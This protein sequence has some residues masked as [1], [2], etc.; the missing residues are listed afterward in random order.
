MKLFA[1]S[2]SLGISFVM[3]VASTLISAEPQKVPDRVNRWIDPVPA[4]GHW[5]F[6]KDAPDP[7]L[8]NCKIISE[9]HENDRRHF[10][11][12]EST[13]GGAS[14]VF[15][16]KHHYSATGSVFPAVRSPVMPEWQCQV[17]SD[18]SWV[19][20]PI[21]H[22][23]RSVYGEI[24]TIR[25]SPRFPES[26]ILPTDLQD[27]WL[28]SI[29]DSWWESSE[30]SAPKHA[31]P[32][33]QCQVISDDSWV[34]GPIVHKCRS[35]YGEIETIRCSPWFPERCILPTDEW[36]LY[37]NMAPI[38]VISE[39]KCKVTRDDSW[40]DGSI[41]HECRSVYGEIE[42]INCSSQLP[43]RCILPTEK[44]KNWWAFDRDNSPEWACKMNYDLYHCRSIFGH[45]ATIR[46]SDWEPCILALG[47]EHNNLILGQR[48]INVECQLNPESD[49]L[50]WHSYAC[51]SLSNETMSRDCI[52]RE[53]EPCIL[54][55]NAKYQSPVLP[56]WKCWVVSDDSL[57]DGAVIY[58]CHSIYGE[59]KRF[60][61]S[62]WVAALTDEEKTGDLDEILDLFF[63]TPTRDET[64][65][66]RDAKDNSTKDEK[67][68]NRDAKDNSK[69]D[70]ADKK[71]SSESTSDIHK[72]DLGV[73]YVD[74][75]TVSSGQTET[76][77]L[78]F[79][80]RTGVYNIGKRIEETKQEDGGIM[81]NEEISAEVE[82]GVWNK[83]ITVEDIHNPDGSR[84]VSEEEVTVYR[85]G[86]LEKIRK[87][88]VVEKF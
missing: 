2:L 45:Q 78:G 67:V 27:N 11:M 53:G 17:I 44:N 14:Y 56:E 46:C 72:L 47:E 43:E 51:R 86:G 41:V 59:T 87:R 58:K 71:L 54:T 37:R 81:V 31:L 75:G 16:E 30:D 18:D 26:C 34:D 24:E 21:V 69:K 77:I 84:V 64:V 42:T 35:V 88:V 76:D 66:S 80:F 62:L 19:D 73:F 5:S 48:P 7:Q 55:E 22:K 32:E 4:L 13:S 61:T 65:N 82:L 20:G 1:I 70:H 52:V 68:S 57:V 63:K 6:R 49:G 79:G 10:S 38:M 40:D 15:G 12:C 3:A 36:N 83:R 85:L 25:C 60:E 33:W 28:E 9:F 23:C 8:Q 29:G 39:W 74:I 50:L